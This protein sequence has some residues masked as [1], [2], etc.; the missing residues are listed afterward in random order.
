MEFAEFGDNP[1]EDGDIVF[2]PVFLNLPRPPH[3][4]ST[5]DYF[6]ILVSRAVIINPYLI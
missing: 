3:P 6:Y 5:N 1:N 2:S 4:T